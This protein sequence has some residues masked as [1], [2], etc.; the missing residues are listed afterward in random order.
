MKFQV[1]LYILHIKL[2]LAAAQNGRFK[3]FIKNKH[4]SFAIKIKN[5]TK[6][7]KYIFKNG[8][9]SSSSADI[10]ACD[11]AMAWA[12]M[13]TAFKVMASGNQEASVAAL[14]ERTLTVEGD[15]KEFMWFSRALEIMQGMA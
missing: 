10:N 14:T 8:K 2:L 15:L 6:G 12:D 1:L 7:R 13:E 9:I 11:A 3:K 4:L 5:S